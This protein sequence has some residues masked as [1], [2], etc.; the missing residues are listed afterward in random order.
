MQLGVLLS[1]KLT[2]LVGTYENIQLQGCNIFLLVILVCCY[3]VHGGVVIVVVLGDNV[4]DREF[5]LYDK[6]LAIEK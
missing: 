5:G 6:F 4:S 1:T 3:F 2:Q